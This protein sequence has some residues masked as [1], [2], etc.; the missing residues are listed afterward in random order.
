MAVRDFFLWE[1]NGIMQIMFFS[2]LFKVYSTVLTEF[3]KKY[4]IIPCSEAFPTTI[5]YLVVLLSST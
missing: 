2:L 5:G 4:L 3:S 1:S